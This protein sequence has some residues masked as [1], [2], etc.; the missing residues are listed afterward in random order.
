M[1]TLRAVRDGEEKALARSCHRKLPNVTQR[2]SEG[3]GLR[4]AGLFP[5]LSLQF[6]PL[7]CSTIKDSQLS[8]KQIV[9]WDTGGCRLGQ[10]EAPRP[11]GGWGFRRKEGHPGPVLF[12]RMDE[13]HTRS[14]C[15]VRFWVPSIPQE[16]DNEALR[17][18]S[19][20]PAF[21]GKGLRLDNLITPCQP[22]PSTEAVSLTPCLGKKLLP[23]RKPWFTGRL[24]HST[25]LAG[26]PANP[27]LCLPSS[28]S[29]QSAD[30]HPPLP[31]L[32]PRPPTAAPQ[33]CL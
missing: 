18:F 13:S 2:G 17:M 7:A 22:S 14:S 21:I 29:R 20:S 12:S 32:A 8:R 10:F 1:L 3:P 11:G 15:S 9:V 19:P 31:E 16:S 30:I 23:V 4:P 27:T 25:P 6:L 26:P 28:C 24:R 5:L 33:P